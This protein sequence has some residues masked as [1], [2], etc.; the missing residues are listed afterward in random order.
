M[1]NPALADSGEKSDYPAGLDYPAEQ[2]YKP[3][4]STFVKFNNH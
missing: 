1:A 2:D 4:V 3:P